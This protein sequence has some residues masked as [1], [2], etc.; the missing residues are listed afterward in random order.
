MLQRIQ[1]PSPNHGP[2]RSQTRLLVIH[3]SEGAQTFQ[4]LGRFLANPRANVSYHVGFDNTTSNAIGEFVFPPFKSWSAH[5][6]NSVAEHGCC[7][8]PNGAA[9]GWSREDWLNH[10]NMLAACK[11]WLQEESSRYGIPLVK[12][13][14]TRIAEGAK[15]VCGHKDCVD[16]GL[17]GNHVDPGPNFPW[18]VVL[19]YQPTTP[20]ITSSLLEVGMIIVNG[21]KG[22]ALVGPGYWGNLDAEGYDRWKAVPGMVVQNVD[23]RGW[24]VMHAGATHGQSA[25]DPIT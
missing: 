24:D 23:Q 7:C 25:D 11:A 17:G 14:G 13:N 16:A 10:P 19:S 18:D 3:T 1:I 21:P 15:G 6:A 8:T 22:A 2:D 20:P 4:S 12:L 5:K 9:R